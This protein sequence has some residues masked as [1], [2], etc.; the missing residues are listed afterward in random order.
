ME[1][2]FL[3]FTK[4]YFP[5]S[6]NNRSSSLKSKTWYGFTEYG[7]KVTKLL[8]YTFAI[9]ALHFLSYCP[10]VFCPLSSSFI[11]P[12][13]NSL[14][15][16]VIS[17]PNFSRKKLPFRGKSSKG[18]LYFASHLLL[19]PIKGRD[20]REI[21]YYFACSSLSLAKKSSHAHIVSTRLRS[22]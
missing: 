20:R 16:L 1:S 22:P 5:K 3:L 11:I 13:C 19:F 6:K 2:D 14:P 10:K 15:T 8:P 17:L 4:Y 21:I 12:L 18:Q 9:L 7:A